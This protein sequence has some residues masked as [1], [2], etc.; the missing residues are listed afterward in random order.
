MIDIRKRIDDNA[1]ALFDTALGLALKG[2]QNMLKMFLPFIF[3]ASIA[4]GAKFKLPSKGV[5]LENIP[6]LAA[7]MLLQVS[8]GSITAKTAK[9]LSEVMGVYLQSHEMCE[10]DKKVEELERLT[11]EIAIRQKTN[12]YLPTPKSEPFDFDFT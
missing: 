11:K 4:N 9:D 12:V 7:S 2:N 10:T 6:E 8:D 1:E 5:T 3:P